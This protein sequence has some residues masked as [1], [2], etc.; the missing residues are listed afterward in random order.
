M[1][2]ASD[3]RGIGRGP[4]GGIAVKVDEMFVGG[5]LVVDLGCGDGTWLD[6]VG[7]RYRSAIGIDVDRSRFDANH[8]TPADWKFVEADLDAGLPVEDGVADAVRANQVIE[9]VREPGDFLR[10]A[11]RVLRPGGLLVVATPNVRYV[12][13]LARL[14]ILGRGPKTSA[15]EPSPD[16]AWDDGHLHYFTPRD[17]RVV[18]RSAGFESIRVSG[19]IA[20][21]GRY[22]PIRPIASA[23]SGFF[24]V[25]EF[26]S[27]NTL[28]V[29]R[30]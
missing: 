23:L 18:A 28:L 16:R 13:H 1:G 27:G 2:R 30:R 19:L 11:Y 4:K 20:R 3:S 7:R 9:H 15:H 22:Q 25:R 29:A 10:E 26:F 14:V 6:V 21:S 12:R 8:P 5:D 24:P 17:L